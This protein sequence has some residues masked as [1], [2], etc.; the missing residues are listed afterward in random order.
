[1]PRVTNAERNALAGIETGAIVYN[2]TDSKFQGY[3]SNGWV[4][5]H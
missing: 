4:D 2:T 5:L 1:M 3:V